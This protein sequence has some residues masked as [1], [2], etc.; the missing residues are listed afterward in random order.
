MSEI[1]PP[2]TIQFSETMTIR[3][4]MNE[5]DKGAAQAVV[6][7]NENGTVFGMVTDGDIRRALLAGTRL[8]DL[9][10]P[11]INILLNC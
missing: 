7:L 11:I 9:G 10:K 5:I 2:P 4:L 3:N 1:L 6:L 8:E